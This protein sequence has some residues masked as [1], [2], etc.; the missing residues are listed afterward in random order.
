MPNNLGPTEFT[1]N[2]RE[3]NK[4]RKRGEKVANLNW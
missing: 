1:K 4:K 3:K 2:I